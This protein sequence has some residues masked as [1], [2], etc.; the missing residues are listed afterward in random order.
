VLLAS[1]G[2]AGC[3]DEPSE[4]VSAPVESAARA[5]PSEQELPPRE[6]KEATGELPLFAPARTEQRSVQAPPP[7]PVPVLPSGPP[8][9][10]FAYVGKLVVGG[11]RHAVVARGDA[12]F[13]A[14]AGQAI[15]AGYRLESITEEKLLV[16]N[17]DFGVVQTLAFSSPT[18][19]H[20]GL[21]S[22]V[23]PKP[24]GDDVSLQLAGPSQVALGEEFTFT[25]SLD[26]GA[27][28]TLETGSVEV[29]FDPKVLQLG[30]GRAAAGG[31]ARVEISG[32]YMGH[33]A[34]ATM[35]FRVVAQAPTATEIRVVPTSIADGEGRNVSVNVPPAHRLAVV[36][37]G[38]H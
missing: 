32:A 35:Q 10:P 28:A 5:Q 19:Q 30:E 25:V 13:I 9:L 18:S 22:P 26:S 6:W 11:A 31:S 38:G 1:I 34:P 17:L 20:A 21:L 7:A 16:M 8:P 23:L 37:R 12:V 33:P 27:H 36:A 4:R 29:R 2:L 3:S 14:R 24:A 15:G